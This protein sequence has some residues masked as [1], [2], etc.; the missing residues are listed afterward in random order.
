ML[1]KNLEF[2]VLSGIEIIVKLE[3]ALKCIEKS[4]TEDGGMDTIKNVKA[5]AVKVEV[6]TKEDLEAMNRSKI[7]RLRV[8]EQHF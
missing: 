6:L 2:K 5:K 3:G 1:N 7:Q 4:A 8:Y